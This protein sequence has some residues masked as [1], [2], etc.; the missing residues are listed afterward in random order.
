MAE[1]NLRQ[2]ALDTETTGMSVEKGDRLIEIGCV[3]IVDRRLTRRVFHT[4]INPGREVEAGAAA[5]HGM[6]W[7]TLKKEPPFEDVAEDFVA[8]IKDAQLLIHN[9]EFDLAFLDAEL[10]R[11]GL[12][13]TRA[14]CA[15]VLD[16]LKLAQKLRPG[17]RNNLD[18][19]CAAYGIDLSK[20]VKHG[21]DIDAELLALVYLELT[22]GQESLNM[23]TIDDA[24]LP[25]MPDVS[26]LPVVRA[27]QAELK[28]HVDM[29]ERIQ[30][31]DS[32]GKLVWQ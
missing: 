4:R 24:S 20:R 6:T 13:P 32:K 28:E 3:E 19:L 12:E 25:A 17:Q 5:V 9:A 10:T 31:K 29:L 7:E 14:H 27:S 15:D 1:K 22:R 8:F 16:T 21:A 18:A 11:A 26:A 23:V 30:N 2:V